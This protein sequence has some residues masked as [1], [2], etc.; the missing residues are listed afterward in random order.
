MIENSVVQP[1][2][3]GERAY[4]LTELPRKRAKWLIYQALETEVQ[5]LLEQYS[6]NCTKNDRDSDLSIGLGAAV[7][8]ENEITGPALPRPY[9]QCV[10]SGE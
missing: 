6:N 5:V 10:S 2:G 4:P 1:A 7:C 3:R 9:L 8:A